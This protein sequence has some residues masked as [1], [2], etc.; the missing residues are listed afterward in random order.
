[1][2]TKI[3]LTC[4]LDKLKDNHGCKGAPDRV[5]EVVSPG[6]AVHD[7]RT[8]CALFRVPWRGG[9][10]A[11]PLSRSTHQGLPGRHDGFETDA[12]VAAKCNGRPI[13]HARGV[14]EVA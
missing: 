3:S 9:V 12:P 10:L 1:V 6:T 7:Q 8:K 13:G 2:P 11:G 14:E 4:N 5:I